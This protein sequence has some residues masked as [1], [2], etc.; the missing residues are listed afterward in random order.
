MSLLLSALGLALLGLLLIAL[1]IGT[2]VF[3]YWW[4]EWRGM[5]GLSPVVRAYARL[6]RYLSLIGIRLNSQHTPEERRRII[7][8]ALPKAEP[9]VS[10]ITQMYTAERYGGQR[11]ES[12]QQ[13]DVQAEVADDAWQDARTTI[14]Q[15]WLR[16]LLP[17]GRRRR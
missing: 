11:V 9:P 13:A 2:G 14:V 12:A 10:A 4:W 5:R 8:R 6:E 1:L 16:R 3:I 15:R 7:V 17:G